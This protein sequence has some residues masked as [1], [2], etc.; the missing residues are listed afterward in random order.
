[1]R[2]ITKRSTAMS[3][4]SEIEI[5]SAT[6]NTVQIEKCTNLESAF[7][8]EFEKR[9]DGLFYFD[10]KAKTI[11]KSKWG[12]PFYMDNYNCP[13]RT[14]KFHTIDV[15]GE[16]DYLQVFPLGHITKT[17]LKNHNIIASLQYGEE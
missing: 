13:F 14:G 6:Q 12:N 1:M 10:E 17:S 16:K 2:R 8:Y 15:D 4:T 3:E 9:T 5:P 7:H 11:T